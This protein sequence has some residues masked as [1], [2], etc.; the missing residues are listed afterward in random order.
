MGNRAV[1]LTRMV[2]VLLVK[3]LC[4]YLDLPGVPTFHQEV[5]LMLWKG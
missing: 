1:R 5:S 4:L 3:Q 2:W